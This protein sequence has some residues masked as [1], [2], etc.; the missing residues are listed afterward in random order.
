MSEEVKPVAPAV[1]AITEVVVV[2]SEPEVVVISKAAAAPGAEEGKNSASTNVAL[3]GSGVYVQM[4]ALVPMG[5]A[6]NSRSVVSVQKRLVELGYG[7]AADEK[8]GYFGE[9]TCS[10]LR[11]FQEDKKIKSKDLVTLETIQSLF[12]GTAVEILV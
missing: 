10:A 1:V 12:S 9:N 6:R 2:A 8:S 11:Q 3:R 5:S 4:A 7:S